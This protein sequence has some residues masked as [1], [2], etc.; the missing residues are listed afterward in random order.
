MQIA[1]KDVQLTRGEYFRLVVSL[2]LKRL[3]PIYVLL[4]AQTALCLFVDGLEAMSVLGAICIVFF[5]A[6]VIAYVWWFA[7]CSDNKIFFIERRFELGD[8]A[9]KVWIKGGSYSE[10]R[11]DHL[12]RVVKCPKHY[13]VFTSRQGFFCIPFRAFLSREDM[14]ACDAV[15]RSKH[16]L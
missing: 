16:L 8:D 2:L 3:W 14:D 4:V 6:L 13:L 9:I 15:L 1:T 11:Y 5:T 10:I 12:A 7:G